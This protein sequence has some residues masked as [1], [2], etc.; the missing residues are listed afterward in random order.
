MDVMTKWS[1]FPAAP[2]TIRGE[3]IEAYILE[4]LKFMKVEMPIGFQMGKTK[5][6]VKAPDT[7]TPD[8]L[9]KVIT[10]VNVRTLFNTLLAQYN[11]SNIFDSKSFIVRTGFIVGSLGIKGLGYPPMK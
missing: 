9:P 11:S 7:Y 10:A 8:N 5:M 3:D 6:Q 1:G 2:D 4:C